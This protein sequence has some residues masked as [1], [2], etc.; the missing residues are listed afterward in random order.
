MVFS[1]IQ[2]YSRL[3][4]RLFTT[5]IAIFS[6]SV[7]GNIIDVMIWV[8]GFV[9]VAAYIFPQLGMTTGMGQ[10]MAVSSIVN[11]SIFEI[12]SVTSTFISDLCGRKT[13]TYPL[14]L[15]LPSWLVLVKNAC[16]YATRSMVFGACVLPMTKL[17][18]WNRMDLSGM[19]IPKFLVMFIAIN[20]FGGF[21]SL[22]TA[23]LVKDMNVIGSVWTRI[24]FPLWIL[25]C[26]QFSWQTMYQLSPTFANI[27][28]VNPFLYLMEGIRAAALGQEGFLSFWICLLVTMVTSALFGWIGIRRIK[29]RL[30]FV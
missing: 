15:P 7:V 28:L 16:V 13:I 23:S 26:S 2:P 14:T 18:L 8:T 30:D 11:C 27:S 25:G 12:W 3:F 29:R 24:I 22:F 5:D 9:G 19:C 21:F 17:I 20:V 6:K 4:W 1:N 10:F